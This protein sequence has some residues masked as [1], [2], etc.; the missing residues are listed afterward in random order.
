VPTYQQNKASVYRW[1]ERNPEKARERGRRNNR[2]YYERNKERLRAAALERY[3][4][5]K[6]LAVKQEA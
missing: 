4:R 5:K 2:A 6:V 1:V 3:H